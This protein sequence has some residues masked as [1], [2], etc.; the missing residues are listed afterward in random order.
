MKIQIYTIFS[1]KIPLNYKG[2]DL[3]MIKVRIC[4]TKP[5]KKRGYEESKMKMSN[6]YSVF[7]KLEA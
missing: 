7:F 4:F 1:Y 2:E 5:N 6:T 3:R